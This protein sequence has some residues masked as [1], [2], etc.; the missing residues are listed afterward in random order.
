MV[1]RYPLWK[2]LV[3][4][5]AVISGIIYSLP[6]LY[7]EDPAIQIS[8]PP[9]VPL[10][11][12]VEESV[13]KVLN[14]NHINFKSIKK[15]SEESILVRF[16][17]PKTQLT[18]K[19]IVK[20]TL[21]DTYTVALNL[22]PVTPSWLAALGAEP[23]KLGLDLRGGVHFLLEVDVDSAISRRLEGSMADVRAALREQ[24]LRS[25]VAPVKDKEQDGFRVVF[26]DM[27]DRDNAMDFIKTNQRDLDL[28]KEDSDDRFGMLAHLS[29]NAVQEIRNVTVDQTLTTLRNRVNELGVAEAIVQRQ[30][31]NHVVVELPGIQDTARAKDLL[32]KTAT[33]EFLMRDESDVSTAVSKKT[34]AGTKIVYDRQNRPVLLKK[35]PVLT[36]ESITG[37][38]V[39]TDSRDGKPSVNVRAGGGGLGTFKKATRE[40][41]GKQMAVVYI[42]TKIENELVNGEVTKKIKKSEVV[43]SLATIQSALDS[44]F[45]ITGLNFHEAQNLAIMLRAGALPAAISIVEERTVGPSLG[46][47]NIRLGVIS[48]EVGLGLILVT[49]LIYYSLFGL[50]ADITLVMNIV[51][52]VAILS[53]VGATLTLPGIAGIVL[54][55]G[56]AVD[57]NVLIFERIREELRNGM[58]SQAAIHSGFERALA[59][60]VDS[61]LTTLIVGVILFSVGTGPVRGFAVT[62]SIGIVTSMFTA[63]TG[64]R[65][66]VNLIY[67]GRSVKRLMVGI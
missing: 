14:E 55:V 11:A 60:I 50:I 41:I 12:T 22:A 47:E 49:M 37:A 40:N 66:M 63:I 29:Q 23:M 35:R 53:L 25:A 67:G 56:M 4:A 20:Q 19:D 1:N 38:M 64:T 51:L 13:L 17:D 46:Q 16:H 62:L 5:I 43:I 24:K 21:G 36:G 39:G 42:E 65:A 45:Q 26:R 34:P 10:Q 18:A 44:N 3:L 8:P 33:L 27:A 32:G 31:L 28:M 15:F 2:Y 30:G 57:A 48:I 54:T 59:T 9:G 6:N 7:G 58:S 52:L 61:N